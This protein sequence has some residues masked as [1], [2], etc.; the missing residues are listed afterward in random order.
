MTPTTPSGG[1]PELEKRVTALEAQVAALQAWQDEQ[2]RC[3]ARDEEHV[4][5]GQAVTHW[6]AP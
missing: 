4:R 5:Q 1:L 2:D 3:I 6:I